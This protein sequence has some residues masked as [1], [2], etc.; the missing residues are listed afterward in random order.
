MYIGHYKS[1]RELENLEN[2]EIL[3]SIT[4]PFPEI[5][6]MKNLT[7]LTILAVTNFTDTKC[8]LK[9]LK[10]LEITCST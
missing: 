6:K 2:L 3:F 7:K 9:K 1:I 8:G 10:S 4:N 5:G